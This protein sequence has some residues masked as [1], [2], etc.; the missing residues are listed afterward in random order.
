M[1]FQLEDGWG[2]GVKGRVS[3]D[4][5]QLVRAE[6]QE[7][8]HYYSFHKEQVYQVQGD[9]ASVNNSTH[10]VLH[11]KNDDP[12]RDM[13]V[14]FIRMQLLDYAGGTALPNVATYWDVGFGRTVSSG[15]AAVTPVNM[16]RKS[17]NTASG[18]F[19]DNNPTMAG[20]FVEFDRWY[21][22]EEGQ[23]LVY[24]KQGSVVLGL[25]DTLEI[26]ITSDHTSGVAQ[27]RVTFMMIP[28]TVI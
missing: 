8:Q 11:L 2:S 19:T 5:Q 24:S 22:K 12:D 17:G 25:N 23:M 6:S 21:P 4:G 28:K 10:A 9:F 14:S 16:N 20:T 13:V 26:R 18:T 3:T 7:L 1:S 27:A 15:G